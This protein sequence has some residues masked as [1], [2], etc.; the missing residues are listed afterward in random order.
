L[1]PTPA[2]D[3]ARRRDPKREETPPRA[4]RHFAPRV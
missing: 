2:R 1:Q 3:A 4:A